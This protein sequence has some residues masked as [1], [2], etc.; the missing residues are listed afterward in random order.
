MSIEE[1]MKKLNQIGEESQGQPLDPMCFKGFPFAVT[2]QNILLPCCYLDT[3]G[4]MQHESMQDLIA[5]SNIDD[6]ETIDEI[7]LT[8]PWQKFYKDL[9]NNYGPPACHHTC[10]RKSGPVRQDVHIDPK[11][12]S[13]KKTVNF[14]DESYNERVKDE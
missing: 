14:G 7:L 10:S 4:N 6:Y 9:K 2:N 8:E 13:K 3:L 5:V 1:A 12:K 11:D